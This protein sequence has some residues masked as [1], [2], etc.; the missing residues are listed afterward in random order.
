MIKRYGTPP[1]ANTA[2]KISEPFGLLDY[3][4]LEHLNPGSPM[5]DELVGTKVPPASVARQ[6]RQKYPNKNISTEVKGYGTFLVGPDGW[7]LV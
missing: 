1:D 5:S 4:G 6:L 2:Q 3:L 7:E